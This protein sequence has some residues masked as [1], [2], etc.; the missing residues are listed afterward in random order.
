MLSLQ[1]AQ[2]DTLK[3]S[4]LDQINRRIKALRRGISGG[5]NGSERNGRL[6]RPQAIEANHNIRAENMPLAIFQLSLVLQLVLQQQ[7]QELAQA[8][9]PARWF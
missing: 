7:Q 2:T 3:Q 6:F 5:V 9:P 4:K 8:A 1:N